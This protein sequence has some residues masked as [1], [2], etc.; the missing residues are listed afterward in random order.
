MPLKRHAYGMTVKPPLKGGILEQQL[1]DYLN[2]GNTTPALVDDSQRSIDGHVA[3]ED[4]VIVGKDNSLPLFVAE[5]F[6]G[7][8]RIVA[9]RNFE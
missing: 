9:V 7:T 8:Q 6:G 5:L 1:S 4:L 3:L 2:L